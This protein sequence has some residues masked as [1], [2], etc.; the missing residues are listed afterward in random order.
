[1]PR[2]PCGTR[3]WGSGIAAGRIGIPNLEKYTH[4]ILVGALVQPPSL[5]D[6]IKTAM[7]LSATPRN[8]CNTPKRIECPKGSR[9][10]IVGFQGPITLQG[11]DFGS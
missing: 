4:N 5:L 9:A 6:L 10:Q 3:A 7:E 8:F 11:M 2:M 1:M